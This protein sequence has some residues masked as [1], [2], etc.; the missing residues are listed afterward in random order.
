MRPTRNLF[1]IA[2]APSYVLLA[3]GIGITP[4]LSMARH[5]AAQN[6]DWQTTYATRHRDDIVFA[7]ELRALGD[8]VTTHVSGESGRLDLAALLSGIAPGAA[9]YACG[10]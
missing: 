10:P 1:A 7:E 8:R 5:L 3:A 4:I 6:M 2:D 9:V